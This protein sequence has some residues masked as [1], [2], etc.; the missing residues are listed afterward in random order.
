MT[1]MPW[2]GAFDLDGLLSMWI[3]F[4]LHSPATDSF[5]LDP[6]DLATFR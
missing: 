6:L 4:D 1:W 3:A 5:D 2:T